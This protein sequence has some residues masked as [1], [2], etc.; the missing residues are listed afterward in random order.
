MAETTI[1]AKPGDKIT[2]TVVDD[3]TPPPLPPPAGGENLFPFNGSFLDPANDASGTTEEIASRI[4]FAGWHQDPPYWYNPAI[5]TKGGGIHRPLP[6]T[7]FALLSAD[8]DYIGNDPNRPIK[9]N[10]WPNPPTQP[11]ATA[12]IDFIDRLPAGTTQLLLGWGEA[13]HLQAGHPEYDGRATLEVLGRNDSAE[14]WTVLYKLEGMASPIVTQETRTVTQVGPIEIDLPQPFRI[15]RVK[16]Y[17]MLIS[18]N[19]GYLRGGFYL[20]PVVPAGWFSKIGG[21]L[22]RAIGR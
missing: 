18:V 21:S 2:I 20:K 6:G 3:S 5:N 22:R 13:H 11:Q 12:W 17:A 10:T 8:R 1:I 19:A 15:I 9:S 16:L 4:T 14:N 7:D